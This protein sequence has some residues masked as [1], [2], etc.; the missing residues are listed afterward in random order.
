ML[1]GGIAIGIAVFCCVVSYAC[2][3]VSGDCS[4]IEEEIE[5]EIFKG[6]R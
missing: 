6:T 1:A 2:C 4:R 3:K 5:R